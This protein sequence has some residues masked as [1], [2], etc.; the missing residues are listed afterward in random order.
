MFFSSS[1]AFRA[2]SC[3][4]LS[5]AFWPDQHASRPRVVPKSG[6]YCVSFGRSHFGVSPV[7]P[8]QMRARVVWI[9]CSKRV[10]SSRLAATSAC[11]ASISATMACC[12]ARG[13][14]GIWSASDISL[15]R[16]SSAAAGSVVK[17]MLT[18]RALR[19]EKIDERLDLRL[20]KTNQRLISRDSMTG[21]V[22]YV[23]CEFSA[24]RRHRHRADSS[25]SSPCA[26]KSL[27][28]SNVSRSMRYF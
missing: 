18:D 10:I 23:R 12:V 26:P 4:S 15:I 6:S 21:H 2:S 27:H 19:L 28:S 5:S 13:G 9:F 16:R 8:P 20:R 17:M 1:L 25:M 24:N 22:D 7:S 3:W 14:R 11:S